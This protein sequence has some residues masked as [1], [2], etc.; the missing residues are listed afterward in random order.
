M[1]NDLPALPS[2]QLAR[3]RHYKG[4]EYEVLGVVRHSESLE[5]LV[6]YR[7]LY[8]NTGSWVRPFAMFLEPVK[9]GGKSQPR[10]SLVTVGASATEEEL[11]ATVQR[12]EAQ[13]SAVQ[14]APV[15]QLMQLYRPL[16]ARFEQDLAACARDLSLAKASAL[17]LVQAAGHIERVP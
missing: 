15:Q 10:F 6:L 16:A 12:M 17:M 7:P 5:P 3:Y 1:S 13:L 8:N 2:I 4:G 14:S 9:H 11:A